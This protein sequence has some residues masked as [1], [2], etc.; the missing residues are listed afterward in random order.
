VYLP[1]LIFSCTMK[2]KSSLLALAHPGGPGKKGRKAVVVG[3]GSY[4]GSNQTTGYASQHICCL[5]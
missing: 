3:G 1:L 4:I 2:S 5:S